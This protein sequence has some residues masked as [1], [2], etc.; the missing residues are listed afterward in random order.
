MAM[1]LIAVWL[2]VVLTTTLYFVERIV[3]EVHQED[4]SEPAPVKH[5]GGVNRDGLF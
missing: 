3:V 4:P 2:S 1:G 5:H